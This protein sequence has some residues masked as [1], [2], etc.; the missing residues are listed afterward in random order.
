MAL[1]QLLTK[2]HKYRKPQLVQMLYGRVWLKVIFDFAEL[3]FFFGSFFYLLKKI[4][5]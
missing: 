4:L 5:G 2:Y 3:N 1:K